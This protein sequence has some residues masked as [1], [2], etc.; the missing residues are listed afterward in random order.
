MIARVHRVEIIVLNYN[1]RQ[2]L[3][4]CLAAVEAQSYRDFSLTLID[5]G[6]TDGSL[7]WLR[8]KY[9]ALSVVA[10]GKNVPAHSPHLQTAAS[11]VS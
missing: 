4:A 5:N 9:P 8:R 7:E 1:G 3:D 10:R 6:S 11:L 2:F